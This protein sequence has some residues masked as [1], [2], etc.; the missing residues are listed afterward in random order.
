MTPSARET[1]ERKR[2]LL[3]GQVNSGKSTLF[4]RLLRQERSLVSDQAGTT[5]DSVEKLFELP[6]VGPILLVDT[7]GL[8]DDTSLGAERQR[9]TQLA[10]SS[11]DLVLYLLSCEDSLDTPI[12]AALRKANVPT[13]PIIA[14]ADLPEQSSWLERQE[15]IVQCFGHAPL[16]LRQNDDESLDTLLEKIKQTLHNVSEPTPSLLGN[17]CQ[18]GDL[19]LLVMPQD[20]AAPAGRLILPQ[21][22]T[23]RALLDRG[24]HALCVT[25]EQL[26]TALS[27]LAAPPQLIITDSQVFA[28]VEPLVPEGCRLT[29]FSILMSAQRGDLQRLVAGAATIGRLTPSSR[30]LIA[31]ACTHAPEGEDIGTVKLPRLLRK[32][33]G[34]TLTIEHVSGRDFP[35]D[36]TPYDLVIH[37]GACMFNRRMLVSRQ[38]LATAQQVPMTNYGLAIA[39]LTGIL[40]KVALP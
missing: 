17:L 7:P 27:Q 33:I 1:S 25:P 4:N 22:Q 6:S 34:E 16:S 23:I 13:L 26:P 38:D 9:V 2:L 24:C 36:L 14:R 11:A 29:S 18:T 5:T 3:V 40:D 28:T 32:R 21:V 30:L 12:I 10:L 39:Y 8:A 19:V 35:E 20:S 31:E 15:E 37:C